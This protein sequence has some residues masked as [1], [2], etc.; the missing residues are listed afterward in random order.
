MCPIIDSRISNSPYEFIIISDESQTLVRID[1]QD[2]S[3][4]KTPVVEQ[5]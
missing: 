3:I 5:G 4:K 1:H 2:L